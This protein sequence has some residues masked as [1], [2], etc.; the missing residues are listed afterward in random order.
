L[1]TLEYF[2]NAIFQNS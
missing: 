1:I 2:L